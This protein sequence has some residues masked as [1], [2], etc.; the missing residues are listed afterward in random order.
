M[1]FS[2][3]VVND[4]M[5]LEEDYVVAPTV[6]LTVLN[7]LNAIIQLEDDSDGGFLGVGLDATEAASRGD[8]LWR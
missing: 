4:F 8:P 2:G 5:F 3:M 6:Y 1:D 7:G